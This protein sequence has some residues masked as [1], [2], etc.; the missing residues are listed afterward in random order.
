MA[1]E[2]RFEETCR[3]GR[4]SWSWRRLVG[5]T[6]EVISARTFPELGLAVRDALVN[7]FQPRKDRWVTVTGAGV[8]H[9]HAGEAHASSAG[10]LSRIPTASGTS[11][12]P[13]ESG[14]SS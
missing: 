5:G 9:F 1:T 2:W 14:P 3:N 13:V 12:S 6:P 10:Q 11:R 4:A 8:I 7:G